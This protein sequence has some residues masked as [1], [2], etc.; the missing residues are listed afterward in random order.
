MCVSAR[1]MPRRAHEPHARVRNIKRALFATRRAA[2]PSRPSSVSRR[3]RVRR[4]HLSLPALLSPL[5]KCA[6]PPGPGAAVR[7]L[8]RGN[9]PLARRLDEGEGERERRHHHP[10]RGKEREEGGRSPCRL[11]SLLSR[12]RRPSLECSAPGLTSSV[13]PPLED[14]RVGPPAGLRARFEGRFLNAGGG[15]AGR[16]CVCVSE[17]GRVFFF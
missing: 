8:D 17:G 7:T 16:A 10:T 2:A 11:L 14:L 9:G 15:V 5:S 3:A 13:H 1:E 6:R 12:N 4:S